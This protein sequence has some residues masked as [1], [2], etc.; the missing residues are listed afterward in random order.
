MQSG[1][2][3]HLDKTPAPNAAYGV[4]VITWETGYN[5]NKLAKPVN[6]IMS[7]GNVGHASLMMRLPN[8]EATKDMLNQYKDIHL[9]LSVEPIPKELQQE[10]GPET[11]IVVYFS[12]WPAGDKVKHF[13]MQSFSL[14]QSLSSDMKEEWKE[15]HLSLNMDVRPGLA[16]VVSDIGEQ[17]KKETAEGVFAS[18]TI[19]QGLAKRQ[20]IHP[21]HF[22]RLK[23]LQASNNLVMLM[24]SADYFMDPEN[25]E[26]DTAARTQLT[27]EVIASLSQL[28]EA[29]DVQS[30]TETLTAIENDPASIENRQAF[31]LISDKISDKITA[32]AKKLEVS[33]CDEQTLIS[34]CAIPQESFSHYLDLSKKLNGKKKSLEET[35]LTRDGLADPWMIQ[36][37]TDQIKQDEEEIR[38]IK[39]EIKSLYMFDAIKGQRPD[40]EVMLPIDVRQLGVSISSNS[41]T[42][43]PFDNALNVEDMF[44][45][46]NEL[47]KTKPSYHGLTKNC[48][49]T[50]EQVLAAGCPNKK[51]QS[52]FTSKNPFRIVT[53]Q[54][55]MG[56]ALKFQNT[57]YAPQAKRNRFLRSPFKISALKVNFFNRFKTKTYSPS[58][59]GDL[60]KRLQLGHALN[61]IVQSCYEAHSNHIENKSKFIHQ[62]QLSSSNASK[63]KIYEDQKVIILNQII[64]ETN[65][66]IAGISQRELTGDDYSAYQACIKALRD[67]NN[68]I[69]K[70]FG[71]ALKSHDPV[72]NVLDNVEKVVAQWQPIIAPPAKPKSPPP[73]PTKRTGERERHLREQA[74]EAAKAQSSTPA[75]TDHTEVEALKERKNI[76]P[77]KIWKKSTKKFMSLIKS[78]NSPSMQ[79]SENISP[80]TTTPEEGAYHNIDSVKS[81]EPEEGE[82]QNLASVQ[83]KRVTFADE[84]DEHNDDYSSIAPQQQPSQHGEQAP[85]TK[86]RT[87]LRGIL[88]NEHDDQ[89]QEKARKNKR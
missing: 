33:E 59:D 73:L 85:S 46:I 37:L 22:E 77:R 5:Q 47:T 60:E 72:S 35:E 87:T 43:S 27:W 45:K 24:K 25:I 13:E 48:S 40:N 6:A 38:S 57:F 15:S 8:T 31:Y 82:Y 4:S 12:W 62:N 75:N 83:K 74:T 32:L 9:G 71:Q 16:E 1:T 49:S 34:G 66:L 89:D 7:G 81:S 67:S 20:Q 19:T 63:Q 23:A 65:K 28:L 10:D 26:T 52:C 29:N 55:V 54:S 69:E 41:S 50:V 11:M 3:K 88:K 30:I 78:S 14:K 64:N 76:K 79:T 84:I 44:A 42:P 39:A 51:M 70:S 58:P 36:T 21:D 56:R 80:S 2:S 61:Q 53:P 86:S 68:H 18:T 17:S